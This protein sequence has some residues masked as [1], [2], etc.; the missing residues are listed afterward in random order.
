MSGITLT[1]ANK[2]TGN[3]MQ[4]GIVQTIAR[5][6][7]VLEVLPFETI[8]GATYGIIREETDGGAG[9]RAVNEDYVHDNP[10]NS[11]HFDELRRLGS[12]VEVD[13]YIE[14]TGNLNNV[15]AEATVSKAKAIANHF[16]QTFFHG[17]SSVNPMEFD[18]LNKRMDVTQVVDASGFPLHTG[19]IHQLLD[20]V[21]GGSDVIFM[22]KKTRR[23]VNELFMAQKAFIEPSQ[24]AFGRPVQRFGEVRIAVVEDMFLPDNSI[25]AM[26]FGADSGV[27]G[28]Q[29]GE[30]SAEDNGLRGTIYE[31]LIE[32]YVSIIITNPKGVAKLTNFSL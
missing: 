3:A 25:Y 15:R 29:A 23:K 32:W 27:V 24:D 4:K 30:V 28:I 1:E 31:T 8:F 14:L 10:T 13:R 16:T 19:L 6:S 5:E 2:L 11:E 7:A 20:K 9:F 18:G 12:K 22:N 17:D 21:Q 26:S